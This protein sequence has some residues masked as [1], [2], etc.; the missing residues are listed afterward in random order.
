[1]GGIY[2]CVISSWHD[3]SGIGAIKLTIE[4]GETEGGREKGEGRGGGGFMR[5]GRRWDWGKGEK[6]CEPPYD[7]IIPHKDQFNRSSPYL[8]RCRV[9]KGFRYAFWP[10]V[11]VVC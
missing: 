7:L 9:L 5:R 8:L 2:L 11:L 1:M 4:A 3:G 6:G 10:G